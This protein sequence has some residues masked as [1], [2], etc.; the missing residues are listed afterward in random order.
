MHIIN[1]NLNSLKN[2]NFQIEEIFADKLG[3]ESVQLK[4]VRYANKQT[5]QFELSASDSFVQH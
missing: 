1:I 2:V 4:S 3:Y 5:S